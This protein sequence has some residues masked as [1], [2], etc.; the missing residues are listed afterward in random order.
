MDVLDRMMK[1]TDRKPRVQANR[2]RSAGLGDFPVEEEP[3]PE[4]PKKKYHISP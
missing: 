2:F 4:L 3:W 1:G